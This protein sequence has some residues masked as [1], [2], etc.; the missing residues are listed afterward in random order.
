MFALAEQFAAVKLVDDNDPS[1]QKHRAIQ[2]RNR[3][4]MVAAVITVFVVA[5]LAIWIARLLGSSR[6]S[7]GAVGF[8]AGAFVYR[9]GMSKED[10]DSVWED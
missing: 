10:P 1:V 7:I 5:G 2:R 6:S 4:A 8:V 3:W 9:V